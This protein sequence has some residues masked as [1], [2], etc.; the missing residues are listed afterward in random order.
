MSERLL[1]AAAEL[2]SQG[3]L[4]AVSTR[5]VAAAAGTQTPILYRQFG[6]KDG[7]LEAVVSYILA[8]YIAEM[9][10]I[11][12]NSVDPVDDLRRLWD[13]YA[14]FCFSQPE[15]VGLIYGHTRRGTAISAAAETMATMVRG[16]IARIGA[17]GRL[18]MSVDRAT[19]LFRSVGVGF[20]VTQLGIAAGERDPELSAFVRENALA[21]IAVTPHEGGR[22]E[23][24]AGHA[25]A[26]GQALDDTVP[27]SRAER[28]VMV[29]WLGRI[30]DQH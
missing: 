2:L 29:E 7:L 19:A 10:L 11:I 6:D 4:D 15:C 21:A 30:A 20:V 25:A 26:L 24:R 22:R 23:S 16:V 8:R 5:A 13:L 27:L 3:G 18:L 9:R 17:D 14:S 12:E 1:E 28:Q